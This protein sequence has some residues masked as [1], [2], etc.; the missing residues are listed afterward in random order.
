MGA[1]GG[2]KFMATTPMTFPSIS[3]LILVSHPFP[4]NVAPVTF[5]ENL[6][7]WQVLHQNHQ[8]LLTQWSLIRKFQVCRAGD[9][10][11][12]THSSCWGINV[13]K[14]TTADMS[15]PLAL[16][17]SYFYSS[18]FEFIPCFLTNHFT[19][20]PVLNAAAYLIKKRAV[21]FTTLFHIFSTSVWIHLRV[22]MEGAEAREIRS[23]S[24][25]TSIR[26]QC[27]S[28]CNLL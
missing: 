23:V 20:S 9:S 21:F 22:G 4:A 28:L 12:R 17:I 11:G 27:A 1:T 7:V 19:W 2:G 14:I 24:T 18:Q 15:D 3:N 8:A 16:S 25:A 5:A 13:L 10:S 6:S 26:V